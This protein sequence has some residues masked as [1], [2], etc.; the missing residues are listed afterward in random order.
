MITLSLNKVHY[1]KITESMTKAVCYDSFAKNI[2]NY[3]TSSIRDS[4]VLNTQTT[5]KNN[6]Y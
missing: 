2:V 4:V 5:P 3:I 1:L 6:N